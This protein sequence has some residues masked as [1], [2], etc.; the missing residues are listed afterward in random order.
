MY[1][2]CKDEAAFTGWLRSALRRVWTKHPAKLQ[3]IQ[4]L[5][6]QKRLGNRKVYHVNCVKCGEATK[7]KDLEINHLNTVTQGGLSKDTFG[8]YALRLLW[9]TVDE[10]EPVCRT[11]HSTITYSERYGVNIEEAKIQKQ[12]IEFCKNKAGK[13]KQMLEDFGYKP[14]ASALKRREQFAN[15]L[16]RIPCQ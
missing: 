14:E 15:H 13:Q 11:C 16:R 9:V 8:D 10:L 1:G 4:D 7:L 3:L 6:F 12:A 2:Y 5:R